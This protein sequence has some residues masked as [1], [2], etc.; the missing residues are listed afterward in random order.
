M[1]LGAIVNNQYTVIEHIGRGGM[2]DVWSARDQ[3]LR[4]MVAIKTIAVGLSGD[5]DPVQLFKQEAQT[6][7]QMEHPHILPIYDFGEHEGNLYIVMRLVTGGS[8][9]NLL[10]KKPLTVDETLRIGQAIA[11]ALD[12]AHHNNIVHLDLKPPNILLDSA[13]SPYLADFGL[14]TVLDKDG[15]ARNPGSGTLLYMA[16]EQLTSDVIDYRA[17]LYSFCIMLYHMFTGR[18]PFDGT[19]PLALRQIQFN[20]DLPEIADLPFA[21]TEALRHGTHRDPHQ[22][23]PSLLAVIKALTSTLQPISVPSL[24]VGQ[25]GDKIDLSTLES[26]TMETERLIQMGDQ[27]L[28]EAVD[29]YTRARHNWAGGQGR[30]IVSLTHFMMMSGYYQEAAFFGLNI[31]EV[32]YQMLLRGAIEH[33]YEL[34]YWWAQCDDT[35]RRWVC[36]HTL[37]SG[38]TPAR[39][40]ALYRLETLPDDPAAPVI[41][42]LVAQA[43]EVEKDET[44]RMIALQVLGTRAKLV[45]PS[46][47]YEMKSEFRGRLITTMTRLGIELQTPAEWMD[48][49]YSPEVDL[50]IAEQALDTSAP[51]VAEAAAR[52]ISKLHSLTAVRHLANAQRSGREGALKAL[53]FVRDESQ[54]LPDV[55]SPLARAYAWLANTVRRL[56]ANPLEMILRFVLAL[57]G[58]WIAFGAHI[59]STYFSQALFTPQRWGNTIAAGLVMGVFVG[60]VVIVTDEFSRRLRGFWAWWLRLLFSGVL[61]VLVGMLAWGGI[62]WFYFSRI[63]SWDLMRMGGAGLALGFVFVAVMNVRGWRALFLPALLTFVPILAS[64]PN[65]CLQDYFCANADGSLWL[66]AWSYFPFAGLGLAI[67]AFVG[68]LIPRPANASQE[69]L[70]PLPD[71]TKWLLAG[72][73]GLAWSGVVW[74]SYIAVYAQNSVTWDTINVWYYGSMLFAT[75]LMYLMNRPQ[76][77]AFLLMGLVPFTLTAIM[78][79]QAIFGTLE[80]L[81]VDYYAPSAYVAPQKEL[82]ENG[83]RDTLLTYR[84]PEQVLTLGIPLA[85]MI[86]LGAYVQTSY[87]GIAAWIGK[88]RQAHKGR[89]AW[90]TGVLLYAMFMGA[91]FATLSLFQIHADPL[92]GAGWSAWGFA[93]FVCAMAVWRWARWGGVGLLLLCVALVGGGALYDARIAQASLTAGAFAPLFEPPILLLWVVWTLA[94]GLGAWGALRRQLWGGLVLVTLVSAWYVVAFFGFVPVSMAVQGLANLAFVAFALAPSWAELEGGRFAFIRRAVVPTKHATTEAA[95]I[96]PVVPSSP[97]PETKPLPPLSPVGNMA[98]ELDATGAMPEA[99]P[100]ASV[101]NMATELDATGA[102]PEAK[103]SASVGNMATELDATGAMPEAKPSASVG[104]MATE[105][106][107]NAPKDRP[108]PVSQAPKIKIDPSALRKSTSDDSKPKPPASRAGVKIQTGLLKPKPSA[109]TEIDP[110]SPLRDD[111]KP[112]PPAS[113]AGVKIQT[114]LL[115]PKPSA[116]TEIDPASTLRDEDRNED[117]EK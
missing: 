58:G 76:A 3:R 117:N 92:W 16:P 12:Y 27:E 60:L 73:G 29:L 84:T 4:R 22:R 56:T 24:S 55:V 46:A 53:A 102:M 78:S 107:P 91:L 26:L 103:P 101:G 74:A 23:P 110:A 10:E 7:A 86:A 77:F 59:Y 61:G 40:R 25:V 28:L 8:L 6:I 14:A 96:A 65:Y 17:D 37:R 69:P 105:L 81:R 52:T 38:S 104:N 18:L 39:V 87:E 34:P 75:V 98:T 106:D 82:G 83:T 112:K 68:W 54:S 114:G 5:V 109:D 57:L 94:I 50:M 99:K 19:N 32:G 13:R 30:F 2:A 48:G 21:V 80:A 51:R 36:L 95:V 116:D 20:D 70:L 111:S 33:D 11:E 63:P 71:R 67:G 45:K 47:R 108:S 9:E 100:S 97:P 49:V 41:P 1:E 90:L 89:K 66:P 79:T 62:R 15:R 93:V 35:S 64:Y 44:A 88:P 115:K 42:K 72:L 31:D 85:F 43:L 113:R